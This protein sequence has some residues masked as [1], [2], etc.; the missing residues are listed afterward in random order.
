MAEGRK[1]PLDRTWKL[2]RAL[3][4]SFDGLTLECT[5][6]GRSFKNHTERL[7]KLIELYTKMRTGKAAA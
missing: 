4:E 5:Y 7:E 6:F 1:G 3:A 2:V